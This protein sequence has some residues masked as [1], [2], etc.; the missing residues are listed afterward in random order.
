[1][2]KVRELMKTKFLLALTTTALVTGPAFADLVEKSPGRPADAK[3]KVKQS[4]VPQFEVYQKKTV[5]GKVDTVRVKDIP[6]LNVGLE[7]ELSTSS[8]KEAE[9]PAVKPVKLSEFKPL[10]SPAPIQIEKALEW[11]GK[12][13]SEA[14]AVVDTAKIASVPL[15]HEPMPV[16]DP[17]TAKPEPRQVEVKDLT[18]VEL[19]LLQALIFLEI[20]KNYPMALGLFAELF[21]EAP[22]IRTEATYQLALTGRGLGLY[23]EFKHRML[24]VLEDKNPEWQK[25][26]AKSLAENAAE[27]DLAL[28]PVLEPQLEKHKIALDKAD[29]YHLNKAKYFLEQDQL[30]VAV[31]A[32]EKITMDSPLYLDALFLKGVLQYRSGKVQE[33]LASMSNALSGLEAKAPTGDL[34]SIAALTLARL[35]FQTGEYKDAFRS[36][37]KVDKTHPE[38][39]QAMIEQ[40]WSQI[41]AGDYEGAAGN[42]FSLHTD[43]FKNTFAPESYVVRTVGYL[44]L[45]QFGD[46]ARVVNDLKRRYA[47]VH[48]KMETYKK[49]RKDVGDYYETV[50][51]FMRDGEAREIDGLPRS[52]VWALARHPN[53]MLEQ[54]NINS[55][56]DQVSRYNKITMDLIRRE[57][58]LLGE[59]NAI[60]GK[61]VELK[62]KLK[63]GESSE[64]VASL[65][66]RLLSFRI[67]HHIVKKAR[68]SIKEIRAQGLAR[69][70]KEKGE[71]RAAASKALAA[72]FDQMM[73]TLSNALDQ[74]DVLQ[75]EL[76]AGAGEHLRYQA[77]GGEIQPREAAGLKPEKQLKWQ[78]KG[79]VWEDELGHYRSSLKNVCPEVE[80]TTPEQVT[81][82]ESK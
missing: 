17:I 54:K 34:K 12:P 47:G 15:F 20:Q 44:N 73:T 59:Q 81:A 6:R 53:F 29:Q 58:F 7:P 39:P 60:R 66:K 48:E 68:T 37:L 40:A 43:F 23:S 1:M 26:A 51:T 75:Y 61:I 69:V 42:M 9:I 38:W 76:Y 14:K 32:T 74:T 27:G 65:E 33:G 2:V 78:F 22:E 46:G 80:G 35:Q 4:G 11:K 67:Q 57:K 25:K 70:E 31:A 18:P 5:N 30:S 41:L 19:K 63:P 24:K 49:A 50:K 21:S 71:K 82:I 77:A 16:M 64:T 28:V 79:E 36:Y 55:L 45:C 62:K 72:R 56:E 8:F 3:L 52:F 10:P 13:A